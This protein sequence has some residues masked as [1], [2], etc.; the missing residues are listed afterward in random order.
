MLYPIGLIN[1]AEALLAGGNQ[2]AN[3]SFYLYTGQFYWTISP[4]SFFNSSAHNFYINVNGYVFNSG[5][6]SVT[7]DGGVRPVINLRAD[8]EITGSGT[9]TDPYHVVGA[10]ALFSFVFFLKSIYYLRVSV[11]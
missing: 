1:V 5:S 3:E 9:S 2:S 11:L 4:H 7:N 6:I 10:W 8:I